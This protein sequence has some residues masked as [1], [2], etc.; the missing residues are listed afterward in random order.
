[1]S[2]E[3]FTTLAHLFV[4]SGVVRVIDDTLEELEV[5]LANGDELRINMLFERLFTNGERATDL[6]PP[7][8]DEVRGWFGSPPLNMTD[9]DREEY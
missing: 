7:S 9:T 4:Y 1:M 3:K 6:L 5:A 8:E 2:V